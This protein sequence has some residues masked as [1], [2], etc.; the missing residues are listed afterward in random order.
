MKRLLWATLCHC[1]CTP[2]IY[3]CW[4]FRQLAHSSP[5]RP[6]PWTGHRGTLNHAMHESPPSWRWKKGGTNN[7]GI[8]GTWPFHT[9]FKF[10]LG[11]EGGITT[12]EDYRNI[13]T[14][15]PVDLRRWKGNL[16]LI[17]GRGLWTS[18][19]FLCDAGDTSWMTVDLKSSEE[20]PRT[21]ARSTRY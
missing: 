5:L 20:H 8:H 21:K 4:A 17:V 9:S 16:H 3:F 15:C 12:G 1:P 11:E 7:Y 14:T 19:G 2:T 6:S 18:C 13:E 10:N